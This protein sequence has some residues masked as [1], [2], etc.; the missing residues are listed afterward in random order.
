[1]RIDEAIGELTR[2]LE[3][4]GERKTAKLRAAQRLGIEALKTIKAERTIYGFKHMFPL[5]GETQE[6]EC[7]K[8]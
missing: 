4:V 7:S 3:Q 6:A 2:D 1:M 8:V 5:P